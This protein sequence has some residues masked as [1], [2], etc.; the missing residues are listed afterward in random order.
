MLDHLFRISALVALSVFAVAQSPVYLKSSNRMPSSSSSS[1]TAFGASS[2]LS[3][4]TLVV[5][6]IREDSGSTGINGDQLN[7]TAPFSGAVYVFNRDGANFP[8]QAYVKASNTDPFD[9]FGSSVAVSGDTMVVTAPGERSA[10]FGV[11]GDENDNNG[12]GLN[13]GAAYVFV[14][15][16]T[17]W[18][19]EAYLKRPNASVFGFGEAAAISGDTIVIGAKDLACIFVR[20]GTTWSQ[21][22]CITATFTVS[23]D[24]F[25]EA[26]AIDGDTLIV[27]APS[28]DSASIGVNGDQTDNSTFNAGAAYV[29]VRTGTV[30]S[31][32]AYL[33][34]AQTDGI[35]EFGASVAIHGD[36][37]VV[38][39]PGESGNGTEVG[40]DPGNN[41]ISFSGAAYI[42]A[43]TGTTWAH[44]AYLKANNTDSFDRFGG[45]VAISGS[46]IAVACVREENGIG[47]INGEGSLNSTSSSGAVYIY[48]HNGSNWVY[49]DYLKSF[50]ARAGESYGDSLALDGAVLFVGA[51]GEDSIAVGVNGDRGD[52]SLPNSGA[53]HGYDLES[54][55]VLPPSFCDGD[56]GDQMG[57]TS[58]P[59]MNDAPPG[60]TGGCLNSVGNSA[61]L[62]ACGDTSV[63]LPNGYPIDLAFFIS[64]VAPSSFCILLSGD[65]VAPMNAM[66][67][68]FGMSSGSQ[69]AAFDGLRCAVLNTRRHGGRNS[70][71]LGAIGVS[72]ST[73]V[74]GNPWGGIG[75][76]Q[77]GIAQAGAGFV[78]GVTRYFQ[79]VHRDDPLLSCM[80]GLNTSQALEIL[81]T[82]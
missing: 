23:G 48:K 80:R 24:R 39:V 3:G 27:G 14:R 10:A 15:A 26:V 16:G 35:D 74:D 38:G 64:G 21:Q 28:E 66:N 79:V 17:S 31:E 82:P 4:S 71:S 34:A 73:A 78:S 59:C 43:R 47:C 56:G 58:C 36:S 13:S 68:C 46:T 72:Q 12:G 51:T 19:Q 62:H 30:W 7:H 9:E 57:C 69:A 6:A 65:A 52:N 20:T 49:S 63:S 37:I 32:Q 11:N 67:P 33:K 54:L 61:R 8:Q 76:P 55:P 18:T 44:S 41:D 25:A 70:N 1:R 29:F 50:T 22:A 53:M 40:G 45:T 81:F 75:N 77:A 2:A 60:T 42:F 5:G